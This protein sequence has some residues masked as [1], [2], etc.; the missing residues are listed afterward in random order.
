[1]EHSRDSTTNDLKVLIVLLILINEHERTSRA[2]D[3]KGTGP[4]HRRRFLD[5]Q[6]KGVLITAR[7]PRPADPMPSELTA[8]LLLGRYLTE[9]S[10][11]RSIALVDLSH[12]SWL[13]V[14]TASRKGASCEM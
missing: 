13:A 7:D 5:R 10:L 6:L 14:L 8:L 12:W 9:D 1:M 3:E 2:V 11:P 4:S